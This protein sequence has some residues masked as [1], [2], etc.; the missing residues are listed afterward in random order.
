MTDKELKTIRKVI[1]HNYVIFSIKSKQSPTDIQLKSSEWAIITQVDGNKTVQKISDNLGLTEEESLQLFYGL[2]RKQLI[3]IKEIQSPEK[4]FASSEFF[5]DLESTLVKTIGPVANYLIN[6]V[7]WELNE[8][9][10]RFLKD[11]IP[12]LIESISHEINDEQ[13]SVLFQQEMLTKI[14]NI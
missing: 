10:D 14:K 2:F 6:D 7:L 4:I 8:K 1:P 11:R 13:K 12:L 3:N 5:V 9:R